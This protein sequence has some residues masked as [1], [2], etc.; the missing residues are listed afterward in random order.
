M[1]SN[2]T[3]LQDIQAHAQ[4]IKSGAHPGIGPGKPLTLSNALMAGEGIAQGD[5]NL[6]VIDSIPKGYVKIETPVSVDLQLVP[7]NTQGAKH[8]LASF[9]GVTLYRHP[10]WNAESLEGPVLVV[11]EAVEAEI[12]HPTHGHV[13]VQG[14]QTIHCLYQKEWSK[15]L[16][17]E[18]RARD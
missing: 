4:L 8:C 17:K 2:A 1:S 14:G 9:R 10:D 13:T 15:E 7:G 18:R 5:L 3:V 12:Q 11:D 16:E 6:V